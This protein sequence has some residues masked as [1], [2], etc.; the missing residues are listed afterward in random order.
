[1][2]NLEWR[3]EFRTKRAKQVMFPSNWTLIRSLG[4]TSGMF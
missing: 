2:V 3:L 4:N 1:M